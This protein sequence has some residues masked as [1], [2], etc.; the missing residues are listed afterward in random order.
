VVPT[1]LALGVVLD[2]V[3]LTFMPGT[4]QATINSVVASGG[5]QILAQYPPEYVTVKLPTTNQL[6]DAV[7]HYQSDPNVLV[8]LPNTLVDSQGPNPFPTGNPNDPPY[9][10][11]PPTGFESLNLTTVTALNA[12]RVTTGST[13][14]VAA[15]IDN[16][17]DMLEGDL[18]D[19]IWIN[20]G[21]IPASI[22]PLIHK[23]GNHVTFRDLND[24][25][26]AN[27]AI[28]NKA[29]HAPID[30]CDPLDLVN[31]IPGSIYGWQDGNDNDGDTLAD[32]IF[33]WNFDDNTNL[34]KVNPASAVPYHGTGVAGILGAVGNNAIGTTG[35]AWNVRLML[36]QGTLVSQGSAD[37]SVSDRLGRDGVVRGIA[38]AQEHS[39]DVINLSAGSVIYREDADDPSC[40]RGLHLVPQAKFGSGIA[41]L[42]AEWTAMVLPTAA[43]SVLVV[44]V[45]DCSG[46]VDGDG[47]FY[48]PGSFVQPHPDLE[49][50]FA[51]ET[52]IT[53][54]DVDT[55]NPIAMQ[56]MGIPS[57]DGTTNMGTCPGSGAC[58]LLIAAPGD[59]W[60]MLNASTDPYSSRTTLSTDV[61]SCPGT[62]GPICAGT[63]LAAPL[64]SGAAALVKAN[65]M[66]LNAA[67]IKGRILDNAQDDLG[68]ANVVQQRAA[69]TQPS[70]RLLDIAAAVGP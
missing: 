51:H 24:P 55:W 60:R 44:A 4:D 50:S 26:N 22:L 63:S 17:F 53:V 68:L 10:D 9:G 28:C 19:N 67:A 5:G 7:N 54:G 1:D 25:S 70:G 62:V 21:E 40:S 52:M 49:I 27:I 37:Q 31:G 65:N 45:N 34:P 39:A 35:V 8:A 64:V 56:P 46:P 32:D 30:V 18:L 43:N 15:V 57:L 66:G 48:W 20:E 41:G 29:N 36:L 42:A 58:S 69:A 59:R 61:T 6:P 13:D 11:A 47:I 3:V 38:F 2:Q 16:G 23:Q 33:G 14:V 12:W